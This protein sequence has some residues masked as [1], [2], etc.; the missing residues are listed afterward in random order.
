MIVVLNVKRKI[1]FRENSSYTVDSCGY[2]SNDKLFN[3]LDAEIFAK[4]RT[5]GVCGG[6]RTRCYPFRGLTFS[7]PHHAGPSFCLSLSRVFNLLIVATSDQPSTVL[8]FLTLF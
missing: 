6:E 1:G 4:L 8:V 3:L 7:P 5:A 2:H